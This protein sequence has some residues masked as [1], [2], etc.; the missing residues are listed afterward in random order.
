[1]TWKKK[2]VLSLSLSVD[3]KA[4]SLK[5][6][7]LV[8]CGSGD[9]VNITMTNALNEEACPGANLWHMYFDEDRL[10]FHVFDN[11]RSSN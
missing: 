10:Q 4:I 1:M 3:I 8:C 9:T 6:N 7:S 11:I 5:S 2:A